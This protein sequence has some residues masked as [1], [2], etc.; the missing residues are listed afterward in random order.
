[1]ILTVRPVLLGDLDDDDDVDLFDLAILANNWLVDIGFDPLPDTT[2]PDPDPM[3]WAEGG[4]PREIQCPGGYCATMTAKIATDP[5]G[6]VQYEF[7][8]TDVGGFSSGWQGSPSYT[9]LVGTFDGHDNIFR[10]RARDIHDNRTDWSDA[11]PMN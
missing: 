11:L 3:D 1:M 8:C 6:G 2:P 10:V 9:V 4:E 7:Q 5:S